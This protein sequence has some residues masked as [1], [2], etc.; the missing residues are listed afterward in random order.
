[1]TRWSHVALNTR[2]LER[3][4]RFYTRWFAFTR[5]A[6]FDLDPGRILFLR[7]GDAYLELFGPATPQPAAGPPAAGDG[8]A[9][10]GS[11]RHIAFQVDDVDALLAEMGAEA[12]VT[13]GPLDFDAFVP[14]WRTAW[15]SDPDGVVV[16]ISQGF[17]E[18]GAGAGSAD[19]RE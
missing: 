16:E 10:P 7:A 11:V 18:T 12:R 9:D 13:L 6:D 5:V 17:R 3:T 4:E 15:V 19:A 14:G 8:P 2:D 1:M